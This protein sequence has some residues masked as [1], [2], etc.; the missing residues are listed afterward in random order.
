MANKKKQ[1]R[2]AL[3][4]GELSKKESRMLTAGGISKDRIKNFQAKQQTVSNVGDRFGLK[5]FKALREGGL[6]NNKLLKVAAS[7]GKVTASANNKLNRVNPGIALPSKRETTPVYGG[8][9]GFAMQPLVAAMKIGE[10][11]QK[12]RELPKNYYQWQGVN[13]DGSPQALGGFKVPKKIRKGDSV[14]AGLTALKRASWSGDENSSGR[15]FARDGSSVVRANGKMKNKTATWIPGTG[16][17]TTPAAGE[18]TPATDTTPRRTKPTGNTGG[19]PGDGLDGAAST[20]S[21]IYGGANAETYGAP[22][23]RRRRSRAQQSGAVTQGTSRLGTPL[24][25]RSG[26]NIMRA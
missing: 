2:E 9:S 4:D 10:V 5:D 23:F 11:G 26:L 3:S 24:Q 17:T 12:L 6:S 1:I 19:G 20:G 7:S 18:D 16:R 22:T 15:L 13:A 14:T 21:G 8:H 25:R